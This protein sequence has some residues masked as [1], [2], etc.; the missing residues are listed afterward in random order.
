M[1]RRPR[2]REKWEMANPI[3][4]A[5]VE[6]TKEGGKIAPFRK[7]NRALAKRSAKMGGEMLGQH[8]WD[9]LK[10]TLKGWAEGCK[11]LG[12]GDGRYNGQ[13]R[14]IVTFPK[15]LEEKRAKKRTQYAQTNSFAALA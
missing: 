9:D 1:K 8:I 11:I 7:K 10:T 15:A 6:K 14:L 13:G 4:H 2:G 3:D 5:E 12:K